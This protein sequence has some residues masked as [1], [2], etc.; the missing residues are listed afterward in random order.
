MSGSQWPNKMLR[1]TRGKLRAGKAG[2]AK[3]PRRLGRSI[4][5]GCFYLFSGVLQL[6]V[7]MIY[8]EFFGTYI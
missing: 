8:E 7:Y 1:W 5:T 2:L 3:W 4:G 6:M